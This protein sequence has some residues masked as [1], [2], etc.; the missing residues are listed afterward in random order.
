MKIEAYVGREINRVQ[1]K[2]KSWEVRVGDKFFIDFANFSHIGIF[3]KS[4]TGKSYAA[5]V[6]IEE[7]ILAKANPFATII[8]DPLGTF[9]TMRI[10]N[11][12]GEIETWNK[13]LDKND[14]APMGMASK[15]LRIMIP[16]ESVGEFDK[17]MY[18]S[19]FSIS[20]RNFSEDLFAYAFKFKLIDP[21]V[22]LYRKVRRQL[23]KK[24]DKKEGDKRE[25]DF[26][27]EDIINEIHETS[28]HSETKEALIHRLEDL[29]Y[30]EII[31]KSAPEIYDL[32]KPDQAIS[33]NLSGCSEFTRRLIVNFLAKQIMECRNLINSKINLAKIKFEMQEKHWKQR[34]NWY[35]PPVR[36]IID[37][38]HEFLPHNNVLKKYIKEGR[39]LGCVIGFISQSADLGLIDAYAN[40]IH[41]FIGPMRLEQDINALR[42]LTAT[43]K[44]PAEFKNMIK[45]QSNGCFTYF[46]LNEEDSQ[47]IIQFRPRYSHHPASN[48]AEKEKE[49]LI[50]PGDNE[51][52]TESEESEEEKESDEDSET[53]VEEETKSEETEEETESE[54]D[55]E[56]DPELE[57]IK[58]QAEKEKEGADRYFRPEKYSKSKEES[59][60]I[61][62]CDC[63]LSI[64]GEYL[65]REDFSKKRCGDPVVVCRECTRPHQI[66]QSEG[67][68]HE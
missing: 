54:E 67:V 41:L 1:K 33:F 46:N 6:L 7:S 34:I 40:M 57:E 31:T 48:K 32:I 60:K 61:G 58:V 53:E 68:V 19:V 14:M 55:Q 65:C 35:L 38:A 4:S 24:F 3:G 36:L 26:S 52:E 37:E 43:K 30:L 42:A 29:G 64:E 22:S 47:K 18:D 10:P 9:S 20:A 28:Y 51:E 12:T 44:T 16:A 15:K 25:E 56:A 5:G 39:N 17:L 27:L 50:T 13:L 66:K 62:L 11:R 21:Q 23:L 49:F 8:I 2:D 63:L 59:A 45:Q